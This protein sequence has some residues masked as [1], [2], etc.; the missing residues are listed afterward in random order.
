MQRKKKVWNDKYKIP[1]SG[2][3]W[4]P[5]V[6]EGK[7]AFINIVFFKEKIYRKHRAWQL[8]SWQAF[9]TCKLLF[10]ISPG[11]RCCH[12]HTSCLHVK[13]KNHELLFLTRPSAPLPAV[14][15]VPPRAG[16]KHQDSTSQNWKGLIYPLILPLNAWEALSAS[17]ERTTT[18]GHPFTSK[19]NSRSQE[20]KDTW[21]LWP[22]PSM[23]FSLTQLLATSSF[24][25]G[26]LKWGSV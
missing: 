10:L 22:R 8:G 26:S 5:E 4:E 1:S 25:Q 2:C 24:W 15:Q 20:G 19:M 3:L 12:S 23:A 9:K 14:K 16:S 17:R 7:R 11:R 6:G 13:R 18:W 21:F